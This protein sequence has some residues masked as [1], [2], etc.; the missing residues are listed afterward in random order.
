MTALIVELCQSLADDGFHHV[1]LV[2]CHFE[3]EHVEAL[4]A[5]ARHDGISLLE[6]T[7]RAREAIERGAFGPFK[8]DALERLGP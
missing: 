6:L 3:P 8:R 4:R 1:V 5:A 2:N 7:R